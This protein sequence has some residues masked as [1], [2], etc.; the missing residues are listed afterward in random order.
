MYFYYW[1]V[2]LLY[3]MEN[4]DGV[5]MLF[6]NLSMQYVPFGVLII[7]ASSFEQ[8]YLLWADNPT[9]M[10]V[11][12]Y[13]LVLQRVFLRSN[14]TRA[15]KLCVFIRR[16]QS[17]IFK[18]F[19]D[20]TATLLPLSLQLQLTKQRSLNIFFIGGLGNTWETPT[21]QVAKV[22]QQYQ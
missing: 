16:N 20:A 10:K 19:S 12:L 5:A 18:S 2:Y 8:P 11:M 21:G 15:Q 17:C 7:S 6:Y 14:Q 3:V 9:Q 13:V 1:I 22:I 4:T